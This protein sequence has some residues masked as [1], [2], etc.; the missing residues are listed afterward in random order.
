M[1]C[2]EKLE[3]GAT[4]LPRW[5]S[6]YVTRCSALGLCG[7]QAPEVWIQLQAPAACRYMQV[8]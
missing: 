5:R 6:G 4:S 3:W 1:F 8:N 7:S 2:M